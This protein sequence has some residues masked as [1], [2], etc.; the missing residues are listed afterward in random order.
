LKNFPELM[1]FLRVTRGV[2]SKHWWLRYFFF[3]VIVF[4]QY[5]RT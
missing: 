1:G 3:A 4:A 5:F 2:T